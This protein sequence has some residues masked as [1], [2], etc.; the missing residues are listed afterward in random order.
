[1]KKL[2]IPSVASILLF[3]ACQTQPGTNVPTPS[4]SQEPVTQG[5]TKMSLTINEPSAAPSTQEATTSLTINGTQEGPS[6][7]RV[8]K[9]AGDFHY[10]E[11]ASDYVGT[12]YLQGTAKV[13]EMSE[14]FCEENCKKFKYAF[15]NYD[16]EYDAGNAD[17]K[18]FMEMNQGNSFAGGNAIGIGCVEESGLRRM[19]FENGQIK[20]FTVG[21]TDSQTILGAT[22]DATV[23]L[24]LTRPAAVPGMG[25]P[26]CY[27]HFTGVE[28]VK[29][30]DNV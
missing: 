14:G 9:P 22:R 23:L 28:L 21:Q 4:A 26:D 2:L 24:K 30:A 8:M 7:G 16:S 3:A 15:F 11:T 6:A 29:F 10:D 20:E 17:L 19:A 5:T 1:M 27:T 12:L 18:K 13:V 25:A